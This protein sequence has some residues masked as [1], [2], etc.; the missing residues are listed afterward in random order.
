MPLSRTD[1]GRDEYLMTVNITGIRSI[2]DTTTRED[3]DISKLHHGIMGNFTREGVVAQHELRKEV[4]DKNGGM[5]RA[6]DMFRTWNMQAQANHDYITGK[7]KAFSPPPGES[8]HNAARSTDWDI[9]LIEQTL[10]PT[11]VGKKGFDLFWEIYNDLGFTGVLSNQHAAD[12]NATEAWH[13]DYL[14]TFRKLRDR[15][16]YKIAAMAATMDAIGNN[17]IGQNPEYIK[18]MRIQ[19]YLL[20]LGLLR[21]DVTG[22]WNSA[23]E[24]ALD[25]YLGGSGS[26]L[27]FNLVLDHYGI[28]KNSGIS[29]SPIK[30]GGINFAWL[31]KKIITG[32]FKII[33]S[34]RTSG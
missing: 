23:S 8:F 5:L 1:F 30:S 9:V 33:K 7:K 22:F 14:G 28:V 16:G 11:G 2:Y 31:I 10:N 26:H 6:T 20:H 32:F 27:E 12:K 24:V 15:Q 19:A 25:D 4:E 3:L 29:I 34:R 18:N 13:I 21:Q 17:F